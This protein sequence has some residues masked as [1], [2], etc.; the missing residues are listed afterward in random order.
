MHVRLHPTRAARAS[1]GNISLFVVMASLGCRWTDSLPAEDPSRLTIQLQ[2][3]A[4]ADSGM[5]PMTFTCDGADRS[6]PLEWS[7][8]PAQARTLA[9]ICDDPDAPMGTW[10]HWV[11]FNLPSHVSALKEG[12][13]ASEAIPASAAGQGESAP[14]ELSAGRQGKNDFGNS[15]Y[16][17]PCPPGG[18]H[19]Y[20]FRIYA[21]DSPLDLGAGAT[22]AQVLKAIT[23][24][25]LA[26][27][28]LVGKYQRGG[29]E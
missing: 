27:G 13:P 2:S 19:N 28:R 14:E 8:V 20:F 4:F 9:L 22:R 11:V 15:G 18:T 12:V 3:S 1:L 6:P 10:S 23:G 25:I 29:K 21:L 17:G 24:H 5:I 26:E 16:G 7:G